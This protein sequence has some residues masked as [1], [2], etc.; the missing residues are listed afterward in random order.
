MNYF[1]VNLKDR[2][3]NRTVQTVCVIAAPDAAAA[4]QRYLKLSAGE[5][6][7][8]YLSLEAAPVPL[9]TSDA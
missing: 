6:N 7:R 9:V 3:D 4:Y 5:P 8:H 1:V 2:A